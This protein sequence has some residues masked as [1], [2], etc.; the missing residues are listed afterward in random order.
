MDFNPLRA[1]T[2]PVSTGSQQYIP[3]SIRIDSDDDSVGK[4]SAKMQTFSVRFSFHF[5]PD[6]VSLGTQS[7]LSD[8]KCL[9]VEKPADS[10]LRSRDCLLLVKYFRV[11]KDC[12]EWGAGEFP[13]RNWHVQMC[14][15]PRRF[16]VLEPSLIELS[17]FIQRS[18]RGPDSRTCRL[19]L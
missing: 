16:T 11:E 9:S 2:F 1:C 7:A 6:S 17:T 18:A 19:R 14:C 13:Y 5:A 4:K 15:S 8:R 10:P 12:R 3:W